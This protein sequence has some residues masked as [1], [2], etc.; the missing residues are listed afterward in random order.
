MTCDMWLNGTEQY[1]DH[2]I[3][4]KHKKKSKELRREVIAVVLVS[5]LANG[6]SPRTHTAL[7][8]YHMV[9]LH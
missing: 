8:K 3:G 7:I 4:P 9:R 5:A 2:L 1:A 6:L